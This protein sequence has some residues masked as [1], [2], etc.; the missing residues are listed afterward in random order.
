MGTARV[1]RTRLSVRNILQNQVVDAERDAAALPV[2]LQARLAGWLRDHDDLAPLI[3]WIAAR[4]GAD[5]GEHWLRMKLT[6]GHLRQV[7][8]DHAR[9]GVGELR[10]IVR[11]ERAVN[12]A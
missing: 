5:D 11:L 10:T 12:G 4:L 2:D 8:I 3:E 9:I 6:N 1:F 7:G